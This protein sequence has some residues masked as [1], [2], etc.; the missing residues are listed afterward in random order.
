MAR[1]VVQQKNIPY[2]L[3]IFVILFVVASGLAIFFY[4]HDD[5]KVIRIGEL[6]KVRD[7]LTADI[8]ELDK[9]V[10]TLVGYISG[11]DTFAQAQADYKKIL[12][13]AGGD[14]PVG[15]DTDLGLIGNLREFRL[16]IDTLTNRIDDPKDGLLA[17]LDDKESELS[18][19]IEK[20]RDRQVVMDGVIDELN[21]QIAQIKLEQQ[22]ER[23]ALATRLADHTELYTRISQDLER[24]NNDLAEKLDKQ[25]ELTREAKEEYRALQKM[26]VERH[27]PDLVDGKVAYP[28][29]E[30]TRVV[31][32]EICYINLGAGN[33]VMP[34]Q[35]FSVYT[36]SG[37]AEG[38]KAKVIVKQVLE[39]TS[40]CVITWL[41]DPKD[42]VTP[43]DLIANVAFDESRTYTFLVIGRF[44]MHGGN[45]PTKEGREQ[46]I[47][48][49]HQFGG[50]VVDEIDIDVDFVVMGP[51]PAIPPEPE[52]DVPDIIKDIYKAKLK[53]RQDYLDI[54][55]EAIALRLR[56][57]NTNRFLERIGYVPI[58]RLT[59]E[60]EY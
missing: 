52:E 28:D 19:T 59:Y 26:Y 20:E 21:K 53:E 41:L 3:I 58:K 23:S 56:I 32:D 25:K 49:I 39:E 13:A 18:A 6:K 51:E 40:E 8:E 16:Q 24:E 27:Q 38:P 17:Q 11:G 37:D 7:K 29:G 2:A 48:M 4:M 22:V 10:A 33:R 57:L 42:P 9:Q 45:D 44:D 36:T 50:K 14:N 55:A 34:D 1:V 5:G 35:R 43:G 54:K 15:I 31:D 46:I 12:P 30:I 60:E 47:A